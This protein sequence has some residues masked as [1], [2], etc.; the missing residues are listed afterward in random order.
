M[1]E[2]P[3]KWLKPLSEADRGVFMRNL[4]GNTHKLFTLR[5]GVRE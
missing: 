4:G 5:D 3:L 1:A 2:L